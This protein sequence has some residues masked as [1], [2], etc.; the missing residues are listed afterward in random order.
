M[1][2]VIALV[3]L[4][5][6]SGALS[7]CGAGHRPVA[8]SDRALFAQACG[9]CHTLTGHNDPRHQGGD[10]RD[11]HAGQTQFTQLASEMP[12]RRPLSPVQLRSVVRFVMSVEAGR[13]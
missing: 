5:S 8:P 4:V 6:L 13:S 10:L 11:F 7:A 9:A 1:A 3:W 2:R 12:V